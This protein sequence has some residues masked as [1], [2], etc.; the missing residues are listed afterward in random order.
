MM[1]S[2]A[3]VAFERRHHLNLAGQHRALNLTMRMNGKAILPVHALPHLAARDFA[4]TN[5]RARPMRG[6]GFAGP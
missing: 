2:D 1:T 4:L 5:L 3:E 6:L